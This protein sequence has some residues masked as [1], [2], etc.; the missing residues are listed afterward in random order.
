MWIYFSRYRRFAAARGAA[1]NKASLV[2]VFVGGKRA[3][4]TACQRHQAFSGAAGSICHRHAQRIFVHRDR[5]GQTTDAADVECAHFLDRV[6]WPG[7]DVRVDI[8]VRQTILGWAAAIVF[9]AYA[10][11]RNFG[12]D[13]FFCGARRGHHAASAGESHAA[14]SGRSQLRHLPLAYPDAVVAAAARADGME[15]GGAHA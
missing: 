10:N 2:S 9:L 1:R 15:R 6:D 7:G 11:E 3:G 13:D 12:T 14:L 8:R 5:R 4:T